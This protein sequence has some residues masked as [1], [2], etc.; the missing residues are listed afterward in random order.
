MVKLRHCYPVNHRPAKIRERKDYYSALD[1]NLMEEWFKG[2]VEG[3]RMP[4]FH[5]DP[6]SE[7]GYIRK[8]YREKKGRLLNFT[9]KDFAELKEMLMDYLPEDLYY[10]RNVY[11]DKAKCADCNNRGDGCLSCK[12]VLGQELMF[13]VDPENIDCPNCGTL[14]DRVK[15][16]SMFKFCYICFNKAI[17]QTIELHK[18]IAMLSYRKLSTIYSG[19]GFHIYIEDENAYKMSY[20]ERKELAAQVKEEGYAIDPWVTEGEARLARVPYSLNGLVSRVCYPIEIEDIKK[21]NFWRSRP[22]VPGFL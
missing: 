10:D 18:R 14:E 21:L 20:A 16:H 19:R 13:D 1:Y 17:D 3:L 8:E 22:F 6:G 2:K 4:I 12:D 9:V 7:T 15:G 11:R 5:L